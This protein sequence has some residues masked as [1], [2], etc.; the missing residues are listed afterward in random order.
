M[1]KVF[2]SIVV[3]LVIDI[4]SG[5]ELSH[6]IDEMDYNFNDTTGSATILDSYINDYTLEN[7]K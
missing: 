5:T 4:D 2:V 6:V 3:N 1:S 7:S